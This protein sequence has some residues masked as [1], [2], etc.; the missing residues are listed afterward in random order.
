LDERAALAD[1]VAHALA[2]AVEG[3]TVEMRG[4]LRAGT[5]DAY[6]DID[7]RWNVPDEHFARAVAAVPGRVKAVHPLASV[8][9]DPDFARSQKRRLIY[10]RFRDV[11]LF[12]RLDLDVMARSIGRDESYDRENDE[13]R[14]ASGWSRHESAL[15]NG[16]AALK[17]ILRGNDALAIELLRRGAE[18]AEVDVPISPTRRA[19]ADFANAVAAKDPAVAPLAI[20]LR[21]LAR[22]QRA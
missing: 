14:D 3:S 17:A 11:P 9:I 16:I 1:Q 4:S 20:E 5:A 7:M 12:W 18:R 21:A 13:V 2:A 10:V 6:S 15:M 22:D 8:R 19:V